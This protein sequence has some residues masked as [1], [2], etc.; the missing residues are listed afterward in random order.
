M[1]TLRRC[2]SKK[3]V[4][5]ESWL[6]FVIYI[7]LLSL[8]QSLQMVS[9]INLH[10]VS[11]AQETILQVLILQS[12]NHSVKW[13]LPCS[14][15]VFS[16][17]WCCKNRMPRNQWKERPVFVGFFFQWFFRA[18]QGV[19]IFPCSQ[20]NFSRVLLFPIKSIF[21]YYYYFGVP[22]SLKYQ[23]QSFCSMFPALFS[24]CSSVPNNF[25]A[26]SSCSLKPLGKP[27]FLGP[28]WCSLLCTVPL[29]LTC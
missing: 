5:W 11:Q 24:Y 20:Q 23:K 22:C 4:H 19:S 27:L 8:T 10:Q 1:S 16:K 2:P 13:V 28:I 7:T 29:Q 9:G 3:G 25:M 6:D 21:Y 12:W 14:C 17:D 15:Q 18:S 26:M